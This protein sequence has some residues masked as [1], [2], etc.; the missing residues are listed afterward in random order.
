[1]ASR[2]THATPLTPVQEKT[3]RLTTPHLA[4]PPAKN[5][6]SSRPAST[7]PEDKHLKHPWLKRKALS[8]EYENPVTEREGWWRTYIRE[9]PL[10]GTYE[11]GTF[12]EDLQKKQNTYRFKSDGRKIDPHP[13]GKGAVL[14]PG[15]YEFNHFLER[16]EQA[17]ATYNF[18]ATDR[19][20][21]NF[22]VIGHR[23]KDINVSPGQYDMEKFLSLTTDKQSSKHYMFRSQH[24]RFPT[25]P[26]KP[27]E[28]P[29]PGNYEHVHQRSNTAVSSSFKSRTPRFSSS[30][31]RVPGPGMYEKTFQHP[32]PSTVSTM[33]RQH[34]LFFTSAYQS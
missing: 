24:K 20:K 25:L 15:A 19:S 16:L 29:G 22:L 27:K 12:L 1:M 26:F 34:G 2:L 31:T 13:H 8:E 17:P 33:G 14:M 4:K 30:H 23:D 18:K 10:P 21:Q 7:P 5:T 11:G 28:G 3:S 32:I 6:G 9:T